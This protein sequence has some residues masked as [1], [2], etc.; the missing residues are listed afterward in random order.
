MTIQEKARVFA[1]EIKLTPE[2][3]HYVEVKGRVNQNPEVVAMVNDFTEK[4]VEW[5][6]QQMLGGG[7]PP[8]MMKQVQDLTGI[9]MRDPLAAEYIQAQA[10]FSMMINDVYQAILDVAKV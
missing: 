1:D 9:L 10:A 8:D 4:Q 2:Y 3:Q 5:Q 6:R 7:A